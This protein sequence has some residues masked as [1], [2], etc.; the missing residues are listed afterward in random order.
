MSGAV[1]C[2]VALPTDSRRVVRSNQKAEECMTYIQRFD[3]QQASDREL[4]EVHRFI[5]RIRAERQP[6]D[7][8]LTYEGF[9]ANLR[10]VPPFIALSL[11][12]VQEKEGGEVIA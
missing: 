6:D 2:A 4:A 10:N 12:T 11:W 7:P 9:V 8:P 3:P 1:R 5:T